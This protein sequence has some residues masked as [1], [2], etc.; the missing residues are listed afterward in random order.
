[1]QVSQSELQILS[2]RQETDWRAYD[3]LRQQH[4]AL[5]QGRQVNAAFIAQL[6]DT[7]TALQQQRQRN[8]SAVAH[9]GAEAVRSGRLVAELQQQLT[10]LHTSLAAVHEAK[11]AGDDRLQ[12]LQQ[13]KDRLQTGLRDR[14]R[15]A[16]EAMQGRVGRLEQ[17]LRDLEQ[18]KSD[19]AAR[20]AMATFSEQQLKVRVSPC[21]VS[22]SFSTSAAPVTR[23]LGIDR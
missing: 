16:T 6:Q 20:Y 17:Q 7:V 15:E 18:A 5:E 19:L 3:D 23:F 21:H 8:E 2:N 22:A 12:A 14:D 13:S 11:I 9:H 4:D 10:D 1:M